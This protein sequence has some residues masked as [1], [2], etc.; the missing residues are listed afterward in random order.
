MTNRGDSIVRTDKRGARDPAGVL[1]HGIGSEGSP[2]TLGDPADS[3][4]EGRQVPPSEGT[5]EAERKGRRGV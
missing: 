3:C 1:D 2:G 5:T 4:V